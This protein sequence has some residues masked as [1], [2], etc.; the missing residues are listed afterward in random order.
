MVFGGE[1]EVLHW[2]RNQCRALAGS[3]KGMC[4][5]VRWDW[6]PCE[7]GFPLFSV[8]RGAAA[9]APVPFCC[10]YRR[11]MAAPSMDANQ[12]AT[13]RPPPSHLPL[14]PAA[15]ASGQCTGVWDWCYRDDCER[16]HDQS[17]LPLPLPLPPPPPRRGRTPTS[18]RRRRRRPTQAQETGLPP[19][20]NQ[21]RLHAHLSVA[22][23]GR[24]RWYRVAGRADGGRPRRGAATA[25]GTGGQGEGRQGG[26]VP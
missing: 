24:W 13:P 11:R 26:E 8:V 16:W 21:S 6:P 18:R 20:G 19:D 17:C 15:A 4:G 7:F 23:C 22:A 25:H 14:R 2:V 3:A 5:W 12:C 1:W 9:D 10:G